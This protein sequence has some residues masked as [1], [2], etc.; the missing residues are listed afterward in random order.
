MIQSDKAIVDDKEL[1]FPRLLNN[2]I[3]EHSPYPMVII[4]PDCRILQMSRSALEMFKLEDEE[5]VLDSSCLTFVSDKEHKRVL[6]EKQKILA[7]CNGIS[8]V[9][10]LLKANGETFQGEI[11]ISLVG[12]IGCSL[13]YFIVAIRDISNTHKV[14]KIDTLHL[15]SHELRQPI[16][17]IIG[18][19]ELIEHNI[20]KK[21][22][23]DLNKLKRHNEIITQQGAFLQN[24]ISQILELARIGEMQVK[25]SVVDLNLLFIELYEVFCLRRVQ[26]NKP[27]INLHYVALPNSFG[28]QVNSDEVK[29]KQVF[30]NI[31]FNAFKY[32][33]KGTIR[34]GYYSHNET[35]LTFFISD[36]GIGIPIE[37]YNYVFNKYTRLNPDDDANESVGLGLSLSKKIIS[38]LGGDIWFESQPGQGTIFYFSIPRG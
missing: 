22:P 15:L 29:L 38:M 10:E 2:P 6:A 21:A 8:S 1:L 18:F 3:L 12:S 37:K 31:L 4:S 7:G 27:A 16:N 28:Q 35:S 36:T 24:I 9:Y 26:L 5:A 25:P 11:S 33:T 13:G 20:Q 14:S 30:T 19:S 17:A 32:T 23:I 34:F